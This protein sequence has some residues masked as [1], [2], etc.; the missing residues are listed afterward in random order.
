MIA[1]VA[2]HDVAAERSGAAGAN[3]RQCALLHERQVLPGLP[4]KRVGLTPEHVGDFEVR[5]E[6][7][8][9]GRTVTGSPTLG[10]L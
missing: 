3:R 8:G 5:A 1:V 6:R 4:Q 2:G 9:H 7:G 10:C